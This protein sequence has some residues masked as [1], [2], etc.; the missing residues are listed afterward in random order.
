MTTGN[1]EYA[2]ISTYL[3]GR[4]RVLNGPDDH[5]FAPVSSLPTGPT[6][7]EFMAS[8]NLPDVVAKFLIQLDTKVDMLL[9]SIHSSAIEQDFPHKAELLTI[10]ASSLEFTTHEPLAPG[11]WLEL[12]V[13]FRQAGMFI[14]SGIGTVTARRVTAEGDPVFSFSFTRI[15]EEEREKIIRF[16]FKEERRLLRQT[17]LEN[18]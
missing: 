12:V 18:D 14:A 4:Y 11:D 8:S 5:A 13:L 10:S 17:R 3:R 15:L 9:E 16:V 6:R 7:E 2:Q 1:T